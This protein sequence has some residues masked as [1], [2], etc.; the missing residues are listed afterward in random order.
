MFHSMYLQRKIFAVIDRLSL[1][2]ICF[3]G[4]TSRTK[5][6]WSSIC[7]QNTSATIE[8]VWNGI[9]AWIDKNFTET[10]RKFVVNIS[11]IRMIRD[12]P[13]A[14]TQHWQ[15]KDNVSGLY[16][17]IPPFIPANISPKCF[18]HFN[19]MEHLHGLESHGN[20]EISLKILKI[21]KG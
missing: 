12:R 4:K 2:S 21:T 3:T 6:C 8:T 14:G 13:V 7:I 18:R 19:Q 15:V 1:E 17:H 16:K 9:I 10:K 5:A 11:K 20:K